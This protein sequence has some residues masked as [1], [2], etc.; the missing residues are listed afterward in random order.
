MT[1][2]WHNNLTPEKIFGYFNLYLLGSILD[3][4]MENL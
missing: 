4:E 1:T 2:W 3:Q